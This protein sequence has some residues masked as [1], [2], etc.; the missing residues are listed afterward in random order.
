MFQNGLEVHCWALEHT[1]KAALYAGLGWYLGR[2]VIAA[3]RRV[4]IALLDVLGS[5]LG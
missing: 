5:W 2:F 3:S 1:F 4:L